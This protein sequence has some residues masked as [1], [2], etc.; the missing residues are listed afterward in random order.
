MFSFTPALNRF[1]PDTGKLYTVAEVIKHLGIK[2]ASGDE[3]RAACEKVIAA[4]PSQ[5]ETYRKGKTSLLGF[6]IKLVMDETQR[7]ANPKD[8]KEMLERLLNETP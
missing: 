5:V 8:A 1:N 2:L 3:T 6:F 4:N 7:H